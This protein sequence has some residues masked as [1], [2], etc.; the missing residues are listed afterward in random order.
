MIKTTGNADIDTATAEIA[1]A[2]RKACPVLCPDQDHYDDAMRLR[3]AIMSGTRAPDAGYRVQDDVELLADRY[4]RETYPGG[5]LTGSDDRPVITKKVLAAL[6]CDA[7]T[8]GWLRGR[9]G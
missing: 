7:Y 5:Y 9:D 6:L 2:L 8:A 1:V 3:D 4:A